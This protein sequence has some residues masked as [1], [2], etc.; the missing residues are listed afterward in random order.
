MYLKILLKMEF[1]SNGANAPFSIIFS[2][3]SKAL[4]KLFLIFFQ[5][6][7]KIENDVII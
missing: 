1:C 6:Y 5:C 2:K 7:L 4:L 3:V